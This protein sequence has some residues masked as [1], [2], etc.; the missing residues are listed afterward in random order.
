MDLVTYDQIYL[1]ANKGL[2]KKILEEYEEYQEFISLGKELLSMENLLVEDISNPQ[3]L[4]EQHCRKRKR[5]C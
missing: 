5:T 1:R 2:L 3:L 4:K